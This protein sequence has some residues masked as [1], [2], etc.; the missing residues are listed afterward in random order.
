MALNAPNVER[1]E[2]AQSA[3][4]LGKLSDL[5]IAIFMLVDIAISII[6]YECKY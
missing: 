4:V 5:D 6:F 1:Q 3:M 2:T